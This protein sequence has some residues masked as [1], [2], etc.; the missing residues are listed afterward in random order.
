MSQWVGAEKHR[1]YGNQLDQL[2]SVDVA[3]TEVCS[4]AELVVTNQR[5]IDVT[6]LTKKDGNVSAPPCCKKLQQRS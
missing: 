5:I 2:Y 6:P 4:L 1:F 3:V